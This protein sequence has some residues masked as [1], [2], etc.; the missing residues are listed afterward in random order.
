MLLW[1]V[2]CVDDGK[3]TQEDLLFDELFDLLWGSVAGVTAICEAL[4]ELCGLCI[5]AMTHQKA[6]LL[7]SGGV[8]G[9]EVVH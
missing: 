1:C 6:D 3:L 5:E 8:M 4:D 2:V 9:L 7:K